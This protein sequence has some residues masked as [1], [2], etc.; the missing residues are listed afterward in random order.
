MWNW[1]RYVNFQKKFFTWNWNI[2]ITYL[3]QQQQQQQQQYQQQEQQ[4]SVQ[5]NLNNKSDAGEL[6]LQGLDSDLV[7]NLAIAIKVRDNILKI[8]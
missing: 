5:N 6:N 2:S 3:Q 1:N 8:K 4:S 7:R